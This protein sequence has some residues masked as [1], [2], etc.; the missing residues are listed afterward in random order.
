MGKGENQTN[1]HNKAL[2]WL[3]VQM[4]EYEECL[5]NSIPMGLL[6]HPEHSVHTNG[7]VGTSYS[8]RSTGNN[9]GAIQESGPDV[10]P[11]VHN[12]IKG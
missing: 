9:Q 4:F 6:F 2:T 7:L 12:T 5:W 10:H 1:K 3:E 8:R 11:R